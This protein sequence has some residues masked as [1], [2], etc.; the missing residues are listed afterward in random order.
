MLTDRV[1]KLSERSAL[2]LHDVCRAI[3]S[4]LELELADDAARERAAAS[5]AQEESTPRREARVLH[6][7]IVRCLP[8]VELEATPVHVE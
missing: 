6:L 2:L 8:R 7:R 4:A 3:C 5:D 1:T